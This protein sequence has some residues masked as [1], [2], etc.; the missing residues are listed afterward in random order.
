MLKS[1][2]LFKSLDD[3]TLAFTLNQPTSGPLYRS[4]H[5]FA[6]E[7][8]QKNET[9]YYLFSIV[10]AVLVFSIHTEL[11]VSIFIWLQRGNKNLQIY[12][13]NDTNK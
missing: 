5:A 4:S 1:K 8:M 6:V 11:K 2:Q 10:S 3:G 9:K 12:L 7:W 13:K